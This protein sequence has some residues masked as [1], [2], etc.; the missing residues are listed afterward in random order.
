MKPLCVYGAMFSVR[1]F[2]LGYFNMVAL[3][4]SYDRKFLVIL[5]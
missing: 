2:P 5:Q 1:V 4:L 3:D